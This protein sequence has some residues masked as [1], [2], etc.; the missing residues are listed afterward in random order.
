MSGYVVYI[1]GQTI[2]EDQVV[3]EYNNSQPLAPHRTYT[4]ARIRIVNPKKHDATLSY[5]LNEHPVEIR[6]G[7]TQDLTDNRDWV[8]EFDRGEGFG[9]T[10]YS[11]DPG[12]EY[13]FA[14]TENGWELYHKNIAV[15]REER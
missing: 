12:G 15:D 14:W 10:K 6:P 7:E 3:D 9:K 1:E 5:T 11:L 8:I 13:T 4:G 2:P